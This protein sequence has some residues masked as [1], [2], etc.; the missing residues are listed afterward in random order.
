[1][2]LQEV[3]ARNE[4]I[5]AQESLLNVYRCRFNVDTEVVPDGCIDGQPVGGTT[6]PDL[7][8]GTPTEDDIAVRDQLI[9]A[10]ESLLN[11]YRCLFNIDTQIVPGGCSRI[12]VPINNSIWIM[13]GDGENRRQIV[14][15]VEFQTLDASPF[16]SSPTWSPDGTRV[17]FV[18]NYQEEP[19][20][21]VSDKSEIW[22][23]NEDGTDLQILTGGETPAFQNIFELSWSPDG[24]K[25]AFR[26]YCCNRQG[27]DIYSELRVM[28]ADGTNGV[29]LARVSG[30]RPYSWSPD[31]SRI[32][33]SNGPTKDIRI[34]NT[35]GT[36]QR[37]L[38]DIDAEYG[39]IWSPDG[40]QIAVGVTSSSEN[41]K[42]IWVFGADGKNKRRVASSDY[43]FGTPR[44]RGEVGFS[45]SQDGSQIAYFDV[46][47]TDVV[48]TV[49]DA[50]GS[51]QRQITTLEGTHSPP[52][53][54]PDG[55]RIAYSTGWVTVRQNGTTSIALALWVTFADGTNQ[56][57]IASGPVYADYLSWSQ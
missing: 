30:Q 21:G 12:A 34:V 24:T 6:E 7:F 57:E 14:T 31:G 4:L 23:V 9:V 22:V 56:L 27:R 42:E 26:S 37:R 35:D 17:A 11:S 41:R 3:Q 50:D 33:F 49:M 54:S 51:N 20:D 32:V 55:T 2:A 45:W 38:A 52:V 47:G 39:P 1:V 48:L 36:N 29:Q 43:E 8:E 10:Q 44:Q 13:D 15:D 18:V 28:D 40:K 19:W 53:W 16:L 46:Q 25:L 5:A